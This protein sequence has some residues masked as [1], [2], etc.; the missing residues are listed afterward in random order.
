LGEVKPLKEAKKVERSETFLFFELEVASH[1]GMKS[2]ERNLITLKLK[3]QECP[4]NL[5]DTK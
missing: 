1:F 5:K 2:V 4:F 3:W